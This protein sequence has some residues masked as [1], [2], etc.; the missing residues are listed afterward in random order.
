MSAAL[1]VFGEQGYRQASTRRI[2]ASAGVNPP[3]LQYYFGGKEGLHRACGQHI[4]DQV[5]A[6]LSPAIEAARAVR[7]GDRPRA[8]EG[9]CALMTAML[10]GLA[11]PGSESWSRFVN[12]SKADEEGPALAMFHECLF[13]P[14]LEAAVRLVGIATARPGT[15]P[16]VRLRTHALL[17]QVTSIYPNRALILKSLNWSQF[18]ARALE[19]IERVV[20]EHTRAAL[21]RSS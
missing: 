2:A 7:A 8:V 11:L 12:R 4:I 15:D 5:S 14:L 3:A 16:V 17:G 13:M 1:R 9:L 20:I 19:L 6:L 10:S 21:Q 18:D